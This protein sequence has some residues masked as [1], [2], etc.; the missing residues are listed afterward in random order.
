[1]LE[2][3]LC[4]YYRDVLMLEVSL[5]RDVNRSILVELFLEAAY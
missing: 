2:V 4:T 3:S 5:Y 1:M